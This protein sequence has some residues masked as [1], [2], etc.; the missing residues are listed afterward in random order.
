MY[1]ITDRMSFLRALAA[2]DRKDS[3]GLARLWDAWS[4]PSADSSFAYFATWCADGRH[5]PTSAADDFDAYVRVAP[6]AGV[7]DPGSLSV[8][9]STAPC[10]YWPSQP[11]QWAP[12]AESTTVPTLILAATSDPIT[13]VSEA[14]A[15]L[16]RH[17]EARLV[18]TRGGAHGSLGDDC[19]TERMTRFLVDGSLP[20][21]RTSTCVGSIIDVYIPIAPLP[22][23]TADDVVSGL[24]WELFADP[25]VLAW[26]GD[27]PLSFGCAAGGTA[28]FAPVDEHWRT[29]VSLDRCMYVPDA[30]LSGSGTLDLSGWGAE[31]DLTSAR[32]DLTLDGDY[33]HWRITGTWDGDAGL[34]RRV[35][36]RL[37]PSARPAQGAGPGGRSG[38]RRS[39][40]RRSRRRIPPPAPRGHP[41]S[42]P[43]RRR[44]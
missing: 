16:G 39:P 40:C 12:P 5:S 18:E 30:Q 20:S 26:S 35:A 28:T 34:R 22:V 9:Y 32:G 36:V 23:T 3:R 4:G 27:E 10:L 37:R 29:A 8:A 41:R 43:R 1:D 14:R 38:P 15:I 7:Y 33:D 19:P 2:Y 31:L 21:A 42:M 25:L 44:R 13:P 17:P 24:Y 11:E 6:R